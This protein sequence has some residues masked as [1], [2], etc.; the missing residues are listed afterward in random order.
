MAPREP[1]EVRLAR[2]GLAPLSRSA[3]LEIDV[4]ALRSNLAAIRDAVG[5]DVRVEAVVKADAYGHGA[6]PVARTLEASGA[7]G[8]AVATLDEALELREAGIS[9]PLLVLYPVPPEGVE[10]A[11]RGRIAVSV[12]PGLVTARVLEAAARVAAGGSAPLDVHLEIETG[13]GRGGVLPTAASDALAE[14][15]VAPGIRVAGVWTHLAA[16]DDAAS[17][18]GQDLRYGETLAGLAAGAGLDPGSGAIRRHLAA[19]GGVLG[20]R[21]DP[22]GRRPDR[23]RALR[24]RSRCAGGAVGDGRDRRQAAAGD[25]P[26]CT[27]G[28]GR[29]APAGPRRLVRA[30]LRD[31]SSLADRHPPAGVR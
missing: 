9:L 24:A 12:G 11:A 30:I 21:R 27:T 20:E 5:P 17:A 23:D 3:W 28:A 18:A 16:A 29:S 22:L 4:A 14:L 15:L 31:C 7:D 19:S 6:V 8:L 26:V 1:I 2:A 25:G 13:L 10:A